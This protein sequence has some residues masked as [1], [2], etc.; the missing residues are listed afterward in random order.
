VTAPTKV[1]PKSK[2]PGSPALSTLTGR[3]TNL[4]TLALQEREKVDVDF[5]LVRARE[6]VR[7]T[8]ID[9]EAGVPDDLRRGETRGAD[10]H[11]LALRDFYAR[12]TL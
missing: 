3:L 8:G 9:L 10:R 1:V 2:P 7:C 12:L 6:P 5:V 4:P 11:D